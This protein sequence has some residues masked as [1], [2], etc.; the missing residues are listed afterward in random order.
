VDND[1]NSLSDGNDPACQGPT[2]TD[3]DGDGFYAQEGCGTRVD[4]DDSDAGINP[5]A[6]EDCLNGVDDDCDGL[7]DAADPSAGNCPVDCTDADEDG[8][9]VEGNECGPR[10]CDDAN[11]TVNPGATEDCLNGVDDDCDGLVDD[12]DSDCGACVPT[13]RKE[14]GRRCGNDLDDDCDGAVDLEDDDCKVGDGRDH[15]RNWGGGRD[16]T[17][18][19]C[20]PAETRLEKRKRRRR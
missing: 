6:P 2:C 5:S 20:G 18:E 19:E 10:D 13:A 7:V 16:C 1:C 9:A 17:D 14:K 15:P 3:T 11:A 12:Q 4:C 8:Y